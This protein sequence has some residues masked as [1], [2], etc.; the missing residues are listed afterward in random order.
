LSLQLSKEVEMIKERGLNQE[1]GLEKAK[2]STSL[3]KSELDLEKES[4]GG[5]NDKGKAY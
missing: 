2:L 4:D 5:V 3:V 1:D